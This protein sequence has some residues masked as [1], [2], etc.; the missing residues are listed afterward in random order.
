MSTA[1]ATIEQAGVVGELV[2][3]A[4]LTTR[5]QRIQQEMANNMEAGVDYGK[6]PGTP[7]PSLFKPGA[8]KLCALFQI[9]PDYEA[10]DLSTSDC[11]RI[12]VKCIG[13][14]QGTN[15]ILGSGVGEC[16]SDEAKY[17]WRS[18]VCQQEFDET[19]A[20]RRR[21][22]W[23]KGRDKP[24]Q[25]KQVR[26]EPADQA[27][28]VLKMAAKRA[29]VAMALNVTG[30]TAIFTQDIEDAPRELRE[31]ADEPQQTT[32]RRQPQAKAQ[33]AAAPLNEAQLKVLRGKMSDAGMP[34][35]QLCARFK[36]A[37][38]EELPFSEL[39][40]ALAFVADPQLEAVQP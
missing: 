23:M 27:N 12:R 11:V 22:K 2:S 24:Y 5:L 4:S 30:A 19:P 16:S 10:E 37:K 32:S 14:Q 34:D 20:D 40:A 21:V 7:K 38:V 28:T 25:Q 8:E 9:A 18:P 39:N 36:I 17:K 6:I 13:R 3:S 1:V 26:T 31:P 29:H 15:I 35:E 33:A